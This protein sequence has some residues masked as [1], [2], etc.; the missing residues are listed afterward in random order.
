MVFIYLQNVST[1]TNNACLASQRMIT[2]LEMVP[3]K[4]HSPD[5]QSAIPTIEKN[6]K[7]QAKFFDLLKGQ[8]VPKGPVCV[9]PGATCLQPFYEG[10]R[11]YNLF[12]LEMPFPDT[13]QGH[14]NWMVRFF[15]FS[16]CTCRH[17]D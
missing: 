9:C 8:F 15:L 1:K 13:I 17:F 4:L 11:E 5:L 12:S 2:V 7:C 3:Y 6:F 10:M 14:T 16:I